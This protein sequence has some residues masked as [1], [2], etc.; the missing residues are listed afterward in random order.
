MDALDV[1]FKNRI[2]GIAI[3]DNNNKLLG[4]FSA[5]DLRVKF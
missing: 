4:N 5:S 1:L 3:V 2:F